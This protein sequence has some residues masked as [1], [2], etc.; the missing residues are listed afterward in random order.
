MAITPP[1]G[2]KALL[3]HPTQ[4]S[5]DGIGGAGGLR[6]KNGKKLDAKE[7]EEVN[8]EVGQEAGRGH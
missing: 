7:E 4:T 5:Q 3:C 1:S 6:G 8:K 2:G